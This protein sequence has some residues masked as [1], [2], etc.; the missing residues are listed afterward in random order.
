VRGVAFAQTGVQLPRAMGKG[1]ALKEG[2]RLT[3]ARVPRRSS[4]SQTAPA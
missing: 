1:L 4:S 3:T 2:D